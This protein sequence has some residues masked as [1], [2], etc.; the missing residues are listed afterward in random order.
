MNVKG[1]ASR[2]ELKRQGVLARSVSEMDLRSQRPIPFA[3]E[4]GLRSQLRYLVSDA[5]TRMPKCRCLTSVKDTLRQA[6]PISTVG[7]GSRCTWEELHL[8]STRSLGRRLAVTPRV[9]R[10]QAHF[11]AK[12]RSRFSDPIDLGSEIAGLTTRAPRVFP[13]IVTTCRTCSVGTRFLYWQGGR[14]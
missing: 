8:C 3:K 1:L 2:G 7:G 6:M 9:V 4:D 12:R 14:T 5:A 13:S 10:E 11:S